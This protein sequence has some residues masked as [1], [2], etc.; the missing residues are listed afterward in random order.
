MR[1]ECRQG[2][3]RV[4][5]AGS[6]LVIVTALAIAC[7]RQDSSP[8]VEGEASTTVAK[9]TPQ[10]GADQPATA[11]A[12][13]QPVEAEEPATTQPAPAEPADDGAGEAAIDFDQAMAAVAARC[14]SRTDHSALG[15][16][17]SIR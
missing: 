5:V 4:R 14:V 7:G 1:Y 2:R 10:T 3:F 9:A 11:S 8:P 13:S 16:T 17:T 6:A 12:A 15:S